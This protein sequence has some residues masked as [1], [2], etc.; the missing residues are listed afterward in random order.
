M[1][2]ALAPCRYPTTTRRQPA[3]AS[4]S[5][6]PLLMFHLLFL[7][8][9]YT[10]LFAL[11]LVMPGRRSLAACSVLLGLP[12]AWLALEGFRS[13]GRAPGGAILGVAVMTG[14]ICIAAAGFVSGAVSRWAMLAL[15]RVAQTR[16]RSAL[17]VLAGFL[18]IP[19][20]LAGS[21]W[22]SQQRIRV[23]DGA[24]L[25]AHHQV[26]LAGAA[27]RLPSA[28]IFTVW[29]KA[30]KP[31]ALSRHE[32]MRAFCSLSGDADKPIGIV[33]LSID[34]DR[35]L[36]KGPPVR[37]KFCALSKEDWAQQLCH[38]GER[39]A[40]SRQ[41]VPDEIS[42]YSPTRDD[43]RRMGVSDRGAY[44]A[45]VKENEAAIAS[46]RPLQ[47]TQTADFSHYA[48]G[49]W[50]ARDRNWKNDAGEPFSLYCYETK[51]SNMLLCSTT[52][53]L[54]LGPHASYSFR[55]HPDELA[56]VAKTVDANVH[57]FM[58]NFQS[59]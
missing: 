14:I 22:W 20:V 33:K 50:I 24:C 3:P 26:E 59:K 13:M 25:A 8:L 54:S 21:M 49:Y 27:F 48:N 41:G 53:R 47:V 15:P 46:G 16:S 39:T 58:R 9:P 44:R 6:I 23:P 32:D 30:D 55:A 29:T 51:P 31:Y 11:A 7:A 40:L 28:P 42:I 38:A 17:L 36:Y 35:L 18:A 37:D 4:R 12:L 19:S 56:S 1:R 34:T 57:R 52:Y 2:R 5:I 45:F 10:A 43:L